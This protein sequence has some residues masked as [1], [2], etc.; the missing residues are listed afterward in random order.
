MEDIMSNGGPWPA[1]IDGGSH[2]LDPRLT[3]DSFD[4]YRA[5]ISF[6]ELVDRETFAGLEIGHVVGD[7]VHADYLITQ[8]PELV[9]NMAS[10]VVD[11]ESENLG[12]VSDLY[13]LGIWMRNGDYEVGEKQQEGATNWHVDTYNFQYDLRIAAERYGFLPNAHSFSTSGRQPT[14]YRKP[15]GTGYF[16]D[17]FNT[18]GWG[19]M[20]FHRGHAMDEPGKR[21]FTLVTV[22]PP[23]RVLWVNAEPFL[24]TNNADYADYFEQETGVRI[25]V[26]DSL[27]GLGRTRFVEGLDASASRDE[28]AARYCLS[29]TGFDYLA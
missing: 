11:F 7:M 3:A 10:T 18:V 20:N 2:A 12:D 29:N 28:I 22:D 15:D 1:A 23:V 13:R 4:M 24:I 9:R 19:V 14:E 26:R 6:G 17:P 25:P 5:P 16:P 8:A 21:P 27:K